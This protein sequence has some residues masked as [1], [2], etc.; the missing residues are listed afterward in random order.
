[1]KRSRVAVLLAAVVAGVSLAACGG[2]K[3][4]KDYRQ[5]Y[6]ENESKLTDADST[7]KGLRLALASFDKKYA[8]D[9]DVTQ[10]SI[11]DTGAK[12]FNSFNGK[13]YLD[14]DVKFDSTDK[15]SNTSTVQ[16]SPNMSLAPT[17]NW[18][19][20]TTTAYTELYNSNG[21]YGNIEMYKVYNTIDSS[22]IS[23][24]LITPFLKA[25][26]LDSLQERTLFAGN[27]NVGT[28][29]RTK[30]QVKSTVDADEEKK[31]KKK[32][33]LSSE[34]LESEQAEADKAV[35][36]SEAARMSEYQS[37]LESG[38]T[39]TNESGET[40]EATLPETSA[41]AEDVGNEEVTV[42]L[43]KS[44][45]ETDDYIFRVGVMMYNGQ[46]MVYKF[47]YKDDDK[48]SANGEILDSL[49][50]SIKCGEDMVRFGQ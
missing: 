14:S 45:D 13:I 44:K 32:A 18:S 12:V 1:M 34:E 33:V 29:V 3:D 23:E 11:L 30:L 16:L 46:A 15:L 9:A 24:Q 26:N 50:N 40:I 47:A 4:K 22:F 41:A 21:I 6:M 39:E 2:K 31:V 10:Y 48:A 17:D 25:N 42:L 8:D 7:I 37:T 20:N 28:E 19:L 36:E 35:Q 38:K 5:L 49:I 27:V 43:P